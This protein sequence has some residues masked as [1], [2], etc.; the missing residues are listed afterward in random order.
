MVEFSVLSVKL[1]G[2]G[3]VDA[4]TYVTSVT[5]FNV[6]ICTYM[7]LLFCLFYFSTLPWDYPKFYY[8]CYYIK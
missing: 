4:F 1:V 5:Y 2:V 3:V 6:L 7:F 8:Y